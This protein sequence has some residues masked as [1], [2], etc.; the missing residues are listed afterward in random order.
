MRVRCP[1]ALELAYTSIPPY[2]YKTEDSKIAGVFGTFL[3][4]AINSW[5]AGQTNFSYLEVKSGLSGLE[6]HIMNDTVDVIFPI[7]FASKKRFYLG[8]PYV[9]VGKTFTLLRFFVFQILKTSFF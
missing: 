5:C 7:P 3:E 1:E 9:P 6:E 8:R 2:I 4:D